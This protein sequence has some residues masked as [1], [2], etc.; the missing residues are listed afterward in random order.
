MPR[1]SLRLVG[2]ADAPRLMTSRSKI[3]HT[4][5]MQKWAPQKVQELEKE[6]TLQEEF[7]HLFKMKTFF[8][9]C[10]SECLDSIP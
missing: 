2:S 10:L 1:E 9:R 8:F 7:F 3:D 6:D 4:E 5:R